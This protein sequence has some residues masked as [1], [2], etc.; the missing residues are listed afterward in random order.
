[1]NDHDSDTNNTSLISR[2]SL[3]HYGLW[4]LPAKI[5]PNRFIHKSRSCWAENDAVGC[6]FACRFCYVPDT[7]TKKLAQPLAGLGVEDPDADWG[8][9]AFLRAWDEKAFLRSLKAAED[10]Q[11]DQLNADGNRAVIMSSTTDPFPI[12]AGPDPSKNRELNHQSQEMRWR[13]PTRNVRR[14]I[15]DAPCWKSR[16]LSH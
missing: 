8:R 12:F 11:L 16:H 10:P 14:K 1:M 5:N 7:S 2:V 3:Q 9:Y 15:L 6:P 13:S 4:H